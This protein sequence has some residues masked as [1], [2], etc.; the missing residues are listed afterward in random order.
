MSRVLAEVGAFCDTAVTFVSDFA[1]KIVDDPLLLLFC[2]AI[3]VV[4]FGV[5]LLT[6]LI[7]V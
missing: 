2:V 1:S 3:P 5:G 7:R 6:R 4:G